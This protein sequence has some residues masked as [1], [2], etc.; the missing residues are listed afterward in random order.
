MSQPVTR[1]M[2]ACHSAP[3]GE[4]TDVPSPRGAAAVGLWGLGR[5]AAAKYRNALTAVCLD[6]IPVKSLD[7]YV[8]MYPDGVLTISLD[9]PE[10]RT[11]LDQAGT[12]KHERLVAIADRPRHGEDLQNVYRGGAAAVVAL[13]DPPPMVAYV[14]QLVAE[15]MCVI[16]SGFLARQELSPVDQELLEQLATHR[17]IRELAKDNCCSERTM[18]RKLRHLY[19]RLGVNSRT[20]AVKLL[21]ATGGAPAVSWRIS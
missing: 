14:T 12:L 19:D 9:D 21:D 15:G 5:L 4:S 18:Y 7:K 10:Y 8:A 20:E 2:T 13:S 1:R 6:P 3:A 16:P 11:K 17:S